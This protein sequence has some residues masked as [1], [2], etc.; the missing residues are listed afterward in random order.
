M[1]NLD[2]E[3]SKS[4]S[5]RVMAIDRKMPTKSATAEVVIQVDDTNDNPPIFDNTKF[6]INV[7][8]SMAVGHTVFRLSARDTD[9]GDNAKVMYHIT[10]GN[11]D[12]AFHVDNHTGSLVLKKPLDY[13]ESREYRLVIRAVDNN[14]K[15]HLSTIVAIHVMVQDEND[16]DPFFPLPSYVEFIAEN[17]PVGS[18]VFKADAY[19]ADA[20]K[21]G[22]LSY[23]IDDGDGRDKFRINGETGAIT[24]KVVFDYEKENRYTLWVSASDVGGKK[25]TVPV[26]IFV[27]SRDEYTPVFLDNYRFIVPGNAEVGH[28]VGKVEATDRDKGPDGRVVYQLRSS[29]PNFKINRTSGEILVKAPFKPDVSQRRR[30]R[31]LRTKDVSLVVSASSG[32]PGSLNNITVVEITV[33]FMNGTALAASPHDGSGGLAGWTLG[34]VIALAIL[35]VV[36]FSVI[37]FLRFRNRRSGKSGIAQE[38]DSSFD[39]IDIRPPATS[40]AGLSQYP[41]GYDDIAH[42][43][44]ADGPHHH[45]ANTTSEISDQSH[46]ASSGRGSAEEGEDVEDEEIRM[47]NEGPLMQQKLRDRMGMPDSGI[48]QDEDNVS[49]SSVHNTQEYLARLGINTTARSDTN[50]SPR[51]FD[52]IINGHG[53][54]SMTMFDDEGGGEGDGMDITSLIYAKLNDVGSEEGDGSVVDGVRTYG[55]GDESQM[56]MTGS[57]SSI[58]HSE[59]ELTGSYNWDYL[60]DWGPQYQPLAH[61]FAEIAR[62]KDDTAQHGFGGQMGP[63]KTLNPQV[64]AVPPPLI[65]NVA[66][67][68]IAPVALSSTRTSQVTSLPSLPRS[69]IG[70]DSVFSSSAMSPSFSPSLS[71]LATRSP[72][73]SP[74]VTPGSAM[75]SM[76]GHSGHARLQ[77]P[78]GLIN[79]VTAESDNELR[80]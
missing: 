78:S 63:K 49:E 17:A 24:T 77:R 61:V 31:E 59:E 18:S 75:L 39:T 16:N 20:G 68:S 79:S 40:P 9:D 29:H 7:S 46:S 36:L 70:H 67:R 65:T 38:F 10:S 27:D 47:I 35:A 4:Y 37:V 43:S 56:S 64:K 80:I 55:F 53:I 51:D 26:Q 3:M 74:L 71:P 11:D 25:A 19:D 42:Y 23:S 62:L 33:D 13:E 54:D 2:R 72:S 8:E 15:R 76:S 41:P 6:S 66:P 57:L 14:E 22:V 60:L 73:I 45:R 58:V 28:V 50:K 5:F 48:Q 32:R 69:P 21:Y 34:L 30:R 1:G 52:K 12:S 44:T